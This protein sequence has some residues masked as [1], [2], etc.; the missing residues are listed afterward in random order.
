LLK[1]REEVVREFSRLQEQMSETEQL[2]SDALALLVQR[3]DVAQAT[4]VT[5]SAA[6]RQGR[7][8]TEFC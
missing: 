8:S 7:H 2:T 5:G 4:Y 1:E 3:Q 6:L